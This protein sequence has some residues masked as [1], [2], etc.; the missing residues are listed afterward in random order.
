VRDDSTDLHVV[1]NPGS[2]P[3]YLGVLLDNGGAADY[4]MALDTASNTIY[5]FDSTL[6]ANGGI[7]AV[8]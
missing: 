5:M 2:Q 1:A 6:A 8:Q 3:V 4:A 7:L